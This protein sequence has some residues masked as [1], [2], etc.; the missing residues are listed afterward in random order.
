MGDVGVPNRFSGPV[1]FRDNHEN[2]L[3]NRPDTIFAAL[4][5]SVGT[6]G[7]FSVGDVID[8]IDTLCDCDPC[9]VVLDKD[10]GASFGSVVDETDDR[11]GSGGGMLRFDSVIKI[12]VSR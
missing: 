8:G 5:E 3:L 2:G 4:S 6:R 12:I 11:L 1:G 9:E 7:G 10:A